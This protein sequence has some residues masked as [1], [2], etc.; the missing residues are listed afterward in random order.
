MVFLVDYS[1]WVWR[2]PSP[3]LNAMWFELRE[4]ARV[5]RAPAMATVSGGASGLGTILR[6]V[7]ETAA[8]AVAV[9]DDACQVGGLPLML[10]GAPRRLSAA[11]A[12]FRHGCWPACWIAAIMQDTCPPCKIVGQHCRH[13]RYLMLVRATITWAGERAGADATNASKRHVRQSLFARMVAR[14]RTRSRG[15]GVWPGSQRGGGWG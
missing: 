15:K 11:R 8:R 6:P 4:V 10:A 1:V 12:G 3:S 2:V 9:V 14:G 5:I 7:C 13:R